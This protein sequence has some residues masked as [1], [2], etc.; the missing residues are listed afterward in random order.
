VIEHAHGEAPYWRPV[1]ANDKTRKWI[2]WHDLRATGCTW[3]AIKGVEP[4]DIQYRAGHTSFSTTQLYIRQAEAI[5]DGFGDISPPLEMLLDPPELADLW[6]TIGPRQTGK[7]FIPPKELA[8]R[9]GFEPAG[10]G[11]RRVAKRLESD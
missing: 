10:I 1:F 11:S 6:P 7:R 5:R 3:L 8:E 9:A 4:L 2:T